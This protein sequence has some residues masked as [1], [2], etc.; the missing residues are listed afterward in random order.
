MSL[1]RRQEQDC[2]NLLLARVVFLLVGLQ[3]CKGMMAAY[4]SFVSM[5]LRRKTRFTQDHSE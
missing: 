3:Y 4:A 2:Y 5:G 1:T